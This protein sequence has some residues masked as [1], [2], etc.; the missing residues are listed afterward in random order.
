M[1]DFDYLVPESNAAWLDGHG[2]GRFEQYE[3]FYRD[4]RARLAAGFDLQKTNEGYEEWASRPPSG[5]LSMHSAPW[6]GRVAIVFFCLYMASRL[7][8]VAAKLQP[9]ATGGLLI[10][11]FVGLRMFHWRRRKLS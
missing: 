4:E 6:F 5:I 3:R 1:E 9:V 11:A 10:A 7:I 8:P 2:D